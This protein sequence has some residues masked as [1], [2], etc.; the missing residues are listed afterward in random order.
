MSE[1]Q[2]LSLVET[3]DVVPAELVAKWIDDLEDT[4]TTGCGCYQCSTLA[5]IH[6]K[7]RETLGE[8]DDPSRS[9]VRTLVLSGGK[10]LAET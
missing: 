3:E 2:Q 8:G 5:W 6:R 9:Q 4:Y 10:V 1:Y 7:M